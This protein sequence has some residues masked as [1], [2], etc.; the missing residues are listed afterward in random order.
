[1]AV[2]K[3]AYTKYFIELSKDDD[4]FMDKFEYYRIGHKEHRLTE[5]EEEEFS[6]F[7]DLSCERGGVLVRCSQLGEMFLKRFHWI[8]LNPQD[9][10]VKSRCA[11]MQA[12]YNQVK[13]EIYLPDIV[14]LDAETLE[15][16]FFTCSS[17]IDEYVKADEQEIQKY[18]EFYKRILDKHTVKEAFLLSNIL[19]E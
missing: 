16:C 12:L 4:A 15:D 5:Q 19:T 18:E 2:D 1:M 7:H 6:L 3:E 8:Y 11:K 17:T 10:K 13:E 14:P 9:K